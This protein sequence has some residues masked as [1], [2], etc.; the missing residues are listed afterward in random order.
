MSEKIEMSEEDYLKK[1]IEETEK[2]VISA[3]KSQSKEF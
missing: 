1:H 2:S 3:P